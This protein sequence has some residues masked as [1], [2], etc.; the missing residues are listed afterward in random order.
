M[1][2]NSD[3]SKKLYASVAIASALVVGGLGILGRAEQTADI[4]FVLLCGVLLALQ[5]FTGYPVTRLALPGLHRHDD[6][7]GYWVAFGLTALAALTV[8][9][10]ALVRRGVLL[11]GF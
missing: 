7:V 4:L 9:V 8:L 2:R 1:H 10:L 3:R 5:L 11:V 6:P